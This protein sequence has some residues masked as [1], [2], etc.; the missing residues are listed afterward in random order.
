ML[1]DYVLV[2]SPDAVYR[3]ANADKRVEALAALGHEPSDIEE[4]LAFLNEASSLDPASLIDG[5]FNLWQGRQ[6]WPEGRFSDGSYPV[7]YTALEWE[8]AEAEIA[9]YIPRRF[10]EN[11]SG[12]VFY[13]RLECRLDAMSYDLRPARDHFPFLIEEPWPPCQALAR[14]ARSREAGALL[15]QSARRL[16]GS[17][18][19]VFDRR[20]LSAPKLVGGVAFKCVDGVVTT[21]AIG[22]E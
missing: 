1:G 11:L 9:H 21:I 2:R 15:T 7:F 22:S 5:V 12:S 19:P 8:T 20:T 13:D 3:L 6:T 10:G 17:N 18:V 14:E 16:E 4:T